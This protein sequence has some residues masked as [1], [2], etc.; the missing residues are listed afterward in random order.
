MKTLTY[1]KNIEFFARN[2][3]LF[4][5]IAILIIVDALYN[6]YDEIIIKILIKEIRKNGILFWCC[7][8]G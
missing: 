1:Y 7:S 3:I 8:G 2:V 6:N 4:T 5:K